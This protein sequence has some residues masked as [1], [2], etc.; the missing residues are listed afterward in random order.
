MMEFRCENICTL[1]TEGGIGLVDLEIGNRALRFKWLWR[2]E[3]ETGCL[4]RE[5]V[6][7]KNVYDL[8]ALFPEATV[9]HKSSILRQSINSPLLSTNKFFFPSF[10]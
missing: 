4:W 6:T 3:N 8:C 10:F 9:S 5:I 7:A 1:K 2:Y